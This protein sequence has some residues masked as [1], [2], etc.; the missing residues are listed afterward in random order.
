[1]FWRWPHMCVGGGRN[2]Y[3][4]RLVRGMAPASVREKAL[5]AWAT[6]ADHVANGDF[7]SWFVLVFNSAKKFAPTKEMG[8]PPSEHGA[9][10]LGAGAAIAAPLPVWSN[11]WRNRRSKTTASLS[12]LA[13][14]RKQG[15]RPDS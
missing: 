12:N 13:K 11:S 7:P 3:L 8:A 1:M 14:G 10:P 15:T 4:I 5:L 2:R 9:R 6:S